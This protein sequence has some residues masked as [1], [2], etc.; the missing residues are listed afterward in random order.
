MTKRDVIK[1]L[2]E[3]ATQLTKINPIEDREYQA[4]TY[5]T[6]TTKHTLHRHIQI[7]QNFFKSS[8]KKI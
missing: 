3:M 6:I 5:R 7:R 1:K 2:E 8:R 4:L